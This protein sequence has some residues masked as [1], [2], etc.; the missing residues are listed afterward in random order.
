VIF[1]ATANLRA[2]RDVARRAIANFMEVHVDTPLE[3]CRA[4]D[5]K[6]LY[7]KAGNLP[8]VQAPYEAPTNPELVVRGDQ[9]TPADAAASIAAWLEERGWL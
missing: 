5:P 7:K 2:Y 6:G 4:R 9:G 1:D 3:A 8:G